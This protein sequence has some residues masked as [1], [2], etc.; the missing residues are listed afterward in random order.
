MSNYAKGK[1]EDELDILTLASKDLI[2][3]LMTNTMDEAGTISSVEMV[4]SLSDFTAAAGDGPVVVGVAHGDYTN[5]EMEEAIEAAAGSW[6]RSDQVAREQAD[7][8]VRTVGV[9][10]EIG[11]TIDYLNDGLPIKTKLNWYLSTGQ[12]LAIWA[13]NQ[14]TGALTTGSTLNVLGHANIFIKG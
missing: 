2:S 5:A 10:Q 7:R 4:W 8:K 12:T 11:G 6:G 13:Y 9:F 14:G 1:I 3:A